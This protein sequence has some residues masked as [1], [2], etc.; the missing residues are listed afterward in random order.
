MSEQMNERNRSN[1]KA[2]ERAKNGGLMT[3]RQVSARCGVSVRTLHYYDQIGLLSPAVVTAAGYRLYGEAELLRL[4]QILLFRELEFP[5][6]DIRAMLASPTF[7]EARAL[8]QQIALLQLKKEHLEALLEKAREMK[9]K[10][11]NFMDF[12]AFDKSKFEEYAARAKAEWGETEAY[13]EYAQKAAARSPQE[14]QAAGE[15]LMDWFVRFG[16]IKDTD[17]ASAEAQALAK[18]LQDYISAHFYTCTKPIFASLGQMYAAGG[19][20]TENIDRAGGAGTAQFAAAAI[21]RYCEK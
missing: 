2:N 3:V 10:G 1:R 4:S 15:G 14:E 19:E 6:A 12:S 16:K 21:A 17:P 8:N 18:G 7:D 5:L 20:F 9:E 13:K 11:G